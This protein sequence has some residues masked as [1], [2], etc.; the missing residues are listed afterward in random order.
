MQIIDHLVYLIIG[1]LSLTAAQSDDSSPISGLSKSKEHHHHK[2]Q[3]YNCLIQFCTKD[4]EEMGNLG[5]GTAPEN[6]PGAE[7]YGE[8]D[9][10]SV[11]IKPNSTTTLLSCALPKSTGFSWIAK[12][13][14]QPCHMYSAGDWNLMK[15]GNGTSPKS[16]GVWA[17]PVDIQKKTKKEKKHGRRL[18]VKLD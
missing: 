5:E 7:A 10:Q 8:C 12:A 11:T 13:C 9:D 3:T 1:S 4:L 17:V 6:A 2:S 15:A 18:P 14:K 16:Q